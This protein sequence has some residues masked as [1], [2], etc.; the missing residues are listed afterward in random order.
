MGCQTL[1]SEPEKIKALTI[2]IT[3]ELVTFDPN[4]PELNK[5]V[6]MQSDYYTAYLKL[7]LTAK[8]TGMCTDSIDDEIDYCREVIKWIASL[9]SVK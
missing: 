3:P 6:I 8:A 2:D 1:P 7:L 5:I 9:T 4:N